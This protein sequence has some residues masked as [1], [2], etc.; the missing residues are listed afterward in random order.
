MKRLGELASALDLDLRGDPGHP[1]ERIGSLDS[2]NAD[3]LTFLADSRRRSQ[4]AT[5]RAGAIIVRPDDADGVPGNALIAPDPHLAFARAAQLLHPPRVRSGIHATAAVDESAQM[6]EGVAIG[7][8][9][10]IGRNVVLEQGVQIGAGVV[11]EDH[12]TVGAGTIVHPRVTL[13]SGCA[14]GAGCVV[15]SGTVIGSDGF[16]YARD[17]HRW[18]R[19]PQV[20]NV[21]IGDRVDIGANVSIDR[22]AIGDTV[23]DNGVKLDNQVHIAHN[24]HI[25]EHTAIAGCVGISGSTRIGRYCTIAGAV[26]I[27]GHLVIVD[28]VHIT[29]MAQVTKSLTEPGVYSSGTGIETNR[30]WRRN[31]ARFHQLDDIARRLRTIERRLKT[32]D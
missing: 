25:G 1:L 5:S 13:L 15:H 6:G 22:G 12:V 26:G 19:V 18:E 2:A 16:G 10:A 7:A 24:V 20:G 28:N 11:I 21:R 32:D 3:E 23:I 8:Q 9:V 4:L 30:S 17:G 31:V 14:L 29:G 27:A